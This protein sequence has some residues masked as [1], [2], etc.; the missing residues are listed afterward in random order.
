MRLQSGETAAYVNRDTGAIISFNEEEQHL[1]ENSDPGALPDRL[2][3]RAPKIREALHDERWLPL[4]DL[5]DVHE[6]GVMEEFCCAQ[7]DPR[8]FRQWNDSIHG[9]RAFRRFRAAIQRLNLETAWSEQI[10]RDWLGENHLPY[11][12]SR[13]RLSAKL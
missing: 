13:Q 10:A 6:W 3:D 7:D 4:P 11:Q 5:F 12:Q 9:A 8:V 1:V 2:S